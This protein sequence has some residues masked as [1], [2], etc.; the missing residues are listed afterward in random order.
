MST[1]NSTQATGNIQVKLGF[2]QPPNTTSLMDFG[3]IYSELV[4]RTRP[5]LVSAP[6]VRSYHLPRS[7][8]RGAL[9]AVKLT[10]RV[11]HI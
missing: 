3:E 10:R 9:A 6:P 8:M 5:S 4:K 7:Y 1:R 2:V 11:P